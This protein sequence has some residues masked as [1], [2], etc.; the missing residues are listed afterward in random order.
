MKMKHFGFKIYNLHDDSG[1]A[2]DMRAYLGKD[3]ETTIRTLLSK[4]KSLDTKFLLT[5]PTYTPTH[6][7]LLVLMT[8]RPGM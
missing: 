1:C 7:C 8:E 5:F 4:L 6:P 3:T 2:D